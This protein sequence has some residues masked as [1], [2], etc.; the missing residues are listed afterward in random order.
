MEAPAGISSLGFLRNGF[1]VF[2]RFHFYKPEAGESIAFGFDRKR[3]FF[4]VIYMRQ[5]AI[6]VVSALADLERHPERLVDP[7]TDHN[8][9]ALGVALD[10]ARPYAC[11][12]HGGITYRRSAVHLS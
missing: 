6:F 2:Y 8:A 12:A 7:V 4:Q 10:D 5:P 3:H 9:F 11:V 1:V